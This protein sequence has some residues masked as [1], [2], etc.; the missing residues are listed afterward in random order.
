MNRFNLASCA[1]FPNVPVRK[2]LAEP[3]PRDEK[4]PLIAGEVDHQEPGTKK[5]SLRRAPETSAANGH[6]SEGRCLINGKVRRANEYFPGAFPSQ[7]HE[8]APH[9]EQAS[10]HVHD[11]GTCRQVGWWR[12]L[13]PGVH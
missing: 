1:D 6:A 4:H 7:P 3:A 13:D 5:I 2:E 10:E 11:R 9:V 12:T 8:S